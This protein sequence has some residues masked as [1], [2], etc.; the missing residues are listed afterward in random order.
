MEE[1]ALQHISEMWTKK[2]RVYM[3]LGLRHVRQNHPWFKGG[4]LSPI[5]FIDMKTWF[6]NGFTKLHQLSHALVASASRKLHNDWKD[7]VAQVVERVAKSKQCQ[8]KKSQ[9][10]ATSVGQVFC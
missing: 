8:E 3:L 2:K 5:Y 9:Y 1:D 6:H 10:S 7:K 4:P